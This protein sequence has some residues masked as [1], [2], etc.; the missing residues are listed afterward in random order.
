M[1]P[2]DRMVLNP[3]GG[4]ATRSAPRAAGSAAGADRVVTALLDNSKPD[5]A[6]FLDAIEE[7]GKWSRVIR[8]AGLK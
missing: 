7:I 3:E 8:A 4:R 1:N 6:F 2:D 5:V